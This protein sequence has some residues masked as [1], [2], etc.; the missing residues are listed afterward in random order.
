MKEKIKD[1][2]CSVLKG[3]RSFT[4]ILHTRLKFFSEDIK[5]TVYNDRI[6][7][8]H[9]TIDWQGKVSKPFFRNDL[10][11]IAITCEELTPKR[12]NVIIENEDL[13]IIY[14]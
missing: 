14:F 10:I 8:E 2:E 4:R 6:E 11:M 5:H 1:N 9:P 12:Y 7:F 3:A 13:A